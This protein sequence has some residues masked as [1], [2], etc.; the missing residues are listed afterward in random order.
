MKVHILLGQASSGIRDED[1]NVLG[2]V[3]WHAE[4][5]EFVVTTTG[6]EALNGCRAKNTAEL[7]EKITEALGSEPTLEVFTARLIME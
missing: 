3:D 5:S 4:T 6:L 2:S 7:R 1:G